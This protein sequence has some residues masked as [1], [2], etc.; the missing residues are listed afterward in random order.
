MT[1]WLKFEYYAL[2]SERMTDTKPDEHELR[3]TD[4]QVDDMIIDI[5]QSITRALGVK[6]NNAIDKEV[7]KLR[8]TG[9]VPFQ[10]H[11]QRGQHA[12][13]VLIRSLKSNY[14]I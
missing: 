13:Q 2:S 12:T 14:D 8:R 10:Q 5:K 1:L 7:N 4:K 3:W 9:A 6:T 11:G